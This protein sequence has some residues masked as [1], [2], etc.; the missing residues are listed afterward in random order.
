MAATEEGASTPV[1]LFLSYQT[2]ALGHA[3]ADAVG[4]RNKFGCARIYRHDCQICAYVYVY[5]HMWNYFET[6]KHGMMLGSE[7]SIIMLN[8]F[9]SFQED[10]SRQGHTAYGVCK[11][12]KSHPETKADIRWVEKD[13]K[14]R[15]IPRWPHQ[16]GPT[17]NEGHVR[18]HP[19]MRRK[20]EDPQTGGGGAFHVATSNWKKTRM[21]GSTCGTGHRP[22]PSRPRPRVKWLGDRYELTL[23][24]FIYINMIFIFKWIY[25]FN[26]FIIGTFSH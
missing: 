15:L 12:F 25:K 1:G 26:G 8:D 22:S 4:F 21:A 16:P 10:D 7:Q 23:K 14:L 2:E 6:V 13:G 3:Q 20:A 19:S 11:T 5:V 24:F 17:S 9:T 18:P